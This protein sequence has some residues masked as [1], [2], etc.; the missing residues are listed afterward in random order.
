MSED[1]LRRE[2]TRTM[3]RVVGKIFETHNYGMFNALEGNRTDCELRAQKII[4][5]IQ[6]RGYILSPICINEKNE[7][8]DGTGRLYAL[9]QLG[10]PV[11]YYVALGAGIDECIAMNIYGTAWSIKDYVHSYAQRGF[12]DYIRLVKLVD[13]YSQFTFNTVLSI[14]CDVICGRNRTKNVKNGTYKLSIEDYEKA[15][16]VLTFCENARPYLSSVS[17][18]LEYVYAA[19]DF[20]LGKYY[21]GEFDKKRMIDSLRLYGKTLMPDIA[22]MQTAL[23]GLSDIYNYRKKNGKVYFAT[24]YDKAVTV[25]KYSHS[26]KK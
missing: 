18:R 5:S 17:G 14:S 11:H 21:T 1:G 26:N 9:K 12:E 2:R 3:D 13:K 20:L 16:R 7:V 25:V 22:T 24:E 19:F 23:N 6:T 15:D 4:K 8:I 10:M